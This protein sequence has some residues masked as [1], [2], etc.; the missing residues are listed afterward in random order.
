MLNMEFVSA[1]LDMNNSKHELRF[2]MNLEDRILNRINQLLEK[3]LDNLPPDTFVPH[4]DTAE[5]SL[6]VT[7]IFTAIYGTGSPQLDMVKAA[8]EDNYKRLSW[9][10][11]MAI[12]AS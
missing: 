10:V 1:L 2:T 9:S 12:S 4:A 6:A 5:F 7:D 11:C 8:Q 3:R